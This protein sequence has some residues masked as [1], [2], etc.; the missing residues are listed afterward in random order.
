MFSND[1]IIGIVVGGIGGTVIVLFSLMLTKK[2][3]K[4]LGFYTLCII[5]AAWGSIASLGGAYIE[6]TKGGG[7][8]LFLMVFG[9]V[10][11]GL[12]GLMAA[13]G[14]KFQEK[15]EVEKLKKHISEK[16]GC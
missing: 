7:D 11:M 6:M 15:E 2:V 14:S 3:T 16:T 9:G 12:S 4:I 8:G 1:M 10:L 5:V 13:A